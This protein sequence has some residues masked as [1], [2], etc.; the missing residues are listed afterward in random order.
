M[1]TC[2]QFMAALSDY[3]DD[4][5]PA[6]VRADFDRHLETCTECTAFLKTFRTTIS[7]LQSLT[8]EE[9]PPDVRMRIDAFLDGRG[10]N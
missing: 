4:R 3:A 5:L 10:R 6:D 8:E 7:L 2:D 9:L 1:A